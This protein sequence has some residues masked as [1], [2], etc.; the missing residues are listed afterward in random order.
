MRPVTLLIAASSVWSVWLLA[1]DA[2]AANASKTEVSPIWERVA[3]GDAVI[4]A[5]AT[6]EYR[7]LQEKVV[8]ALVRILSDCDKKGTG[9]VDREGHQ[10]INRISRTIRLLGETRSDAAVPI[11][12]E[13]LVFNSRTGFNYPSSSHPPSREDDVKE[14]FPAIGA[15]VEIGKPAVLPS[16]T[17]VA[18]AKRRDDSTKEDVGEG[19]LLLGP[20]Y[21]NALIPNA[22][23][24]I[25]GV[26]GTR[27]AQFLL[28]DLASNAHDEELRSAAKSLLDVVIAQERADSVT[29]EE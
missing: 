17:A 20:D 6:E 14:L 3:S 8:G 10:E 1:G 21:R 4:A 29:A 13:F 18:A 16:I 11:L 19:L 7:Q 27:G 25:V 15:L 22:A 24:V 23:I 5:A 9:R 26:E 2:I 28:K 12:T